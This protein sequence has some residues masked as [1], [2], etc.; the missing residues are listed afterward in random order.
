[1]IATMATPICHSSRA[2][3]LP[4]GGQTFLNNIPPRHRLE[5]NKKLS[6][7]FKFIQTVSEKLQL[8]GVMILSIL[9]L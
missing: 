6:I 5:R 8:L 2:A 3:L 4:D 7:L 1:M 9:S